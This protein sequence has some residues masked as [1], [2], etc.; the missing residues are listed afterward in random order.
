[1]IFNGRGD[2]GDGDA[3]ETIAEIGDANDAALLL[4]VNRFGRFAVRKNDGDLH[5]AGIAIELG[6][7]ED[8][9]ARN[10]E[11]G[12]DFLVAG[13][14]R[15]HG[16]HANGSR[17][18]RAAFLTAILRALVRGSCRGCGRVMALFGD[19]FF[20]DGIHFRDEVFF[21]GFT[22]IRIFVLAGGGRIAGG[23]VGGSA[24]GGGDGL[25]IHD[26][27][28]ELRG[29]PDRRDG[30]FHDKEFGAARFGG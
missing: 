11:G 10:V 9:G 20:G 2:E 25:Q 14:F 4:V 18:E 19:E 7:E 21:G 22:R 28:E 23:G 12:G 27:G 6:V 26:F 17:D 3:A 16:A 15:D 8:A 30:L 5:P 24:S 1:M 13:G 29:R